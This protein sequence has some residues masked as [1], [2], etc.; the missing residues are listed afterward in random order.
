MLHEH[1]N[2]MNQDWCSASDNSF[3]M[4]GGVEEPLELIR[5]AVDERIYVKL[6]GER[7]LWGKLHA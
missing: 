2:G 1:T 6:R 5:L 3:T 7:E 4:S